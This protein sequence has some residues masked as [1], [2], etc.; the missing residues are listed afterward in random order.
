MQLAQILPPY[1]R[2]GLLETLDNLLILFGL[3]AGTPPKIAPHS[4][5]C[6]LFGLRRL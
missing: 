4:A 3:N 2:S 6:A 5:Q 1:C